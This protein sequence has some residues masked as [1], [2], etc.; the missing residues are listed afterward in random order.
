MPAGDSALGLHTEQAGEA[1]GSGNSHVVSTRYPQDKGSR[2]CGERPRLGYGI[3]FDRQGL[4]SWQDRGRGSAQIVPRAEVSLQSRGVYHLGSSR[5]PNF[6]FT[7]FLLRN[8][9]ISESTSP[10]F[11]ED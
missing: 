4:C 8:E 11:R 6:V 2:G 10:V 7:Y 5:V 1:G 3:G 9:Q